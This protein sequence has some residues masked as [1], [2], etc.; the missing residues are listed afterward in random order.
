MLSLLT[1]PLATVLF[2]LRFAFTFS[3]NAGCV[4]GVNRRRALFGVSRML[5]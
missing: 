4:G 5:A 3:H 1:A 2:P